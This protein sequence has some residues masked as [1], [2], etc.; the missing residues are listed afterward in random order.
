L[1]TAAAVLQSLET[2]EV[3]AGLYG[4]LSV[5]SRVAANVRHKAS[6]LAIAYTLHKINRHLQSFSDLIDA[7]ME[8]RIPPDP[9]APPITEE[10]LR[11]L[12]ENVMNLYRTCDYVYESLKRVGLL[13]NSLSSGALRTMHAHGETLLN[14]VDWLELNMQDEDVKA[15]FDRAR[16]E[17]KNGDLFDIEHVG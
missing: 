2:Y 4:A 8:G 16:H 12:A 14:L 17:A 5:V 3:S 7:A 11:K 10:R 13:N 6:V 1:G 15:L 9:N